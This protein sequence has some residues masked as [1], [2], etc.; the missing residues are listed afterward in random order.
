MQ[1]NVFEVFL[2]KKCVVLKK[3]YSFD[4]EKGISRDS[5]KVKGR[6]LKTF[7]VVNYFC[8]FS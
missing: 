2:Y 7:Q 4:E 3:E 8:N 1:L 5:E 6:N